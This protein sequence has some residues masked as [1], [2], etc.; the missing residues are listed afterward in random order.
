MEPL[1]FGAIAG[2]GAAALGS[3]LMVGA[4]FTIAAQVINKVEDYVGKVYHKIVDN[5]NNEENYFNNKV[6]RND[7]LFIHHDNPIQKKYNILRYGKNANL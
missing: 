4:G 6:F 7:N 2:A 1:T 3:G 5:P